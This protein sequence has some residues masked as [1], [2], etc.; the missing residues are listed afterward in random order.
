MYQWGR[1]CQYT[2]VLVGYFPSPAETGQARVAQCAITHR[3]ERLVHLELEDRFGRAEDMPGGKCPC[4]RI[5]KEWFRG[6]KNGWKEVRDVITRWV[7]FARVA[8]GEVV[9]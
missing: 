6:G 7:G 1:S 8:Y 4:G 5:H 9:D 3:V 2:P